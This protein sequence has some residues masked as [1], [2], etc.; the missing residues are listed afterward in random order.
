MH[1]CVFYGMFWPSS[2]SRPV[3]LLTYELGP[4]TLI[5]L[6]HCTTSYDIV[7]VAQKALS[8]IP[9][10]TIAF[11]LPSWKQLI[12]T[13][14]V[15]QDHTRKIFPILT[16]TSVTRRKRRHASTMRLLVAGFYLAHYE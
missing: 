8:P 2:A 16:L 10:D 14:V 13:A 4:I 5:L 3:L 15:S 9:D 12:A 7:V 6:L 1:R 11:A